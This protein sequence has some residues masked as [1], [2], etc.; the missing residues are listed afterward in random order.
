MSLSIPSYQGGRLPEA[1]ITNVAFLSPKSGEQTQQAVGIRAQMNT[2]KTKELEAT[3]ARL[4]HEGKYTP[5][6]SEHLQ[7]MESWPVPDRFEGKT[8]IENKGIGIIIESTLTADGWPK[9]TSDIANN[10]AKLGAPTHGFFYHDTNFLLSA[11]REYSNLEENEVFRHRNILDV[12]FVRDTLDFF[13]NGN[14]TSVDVALVQNQMEG[15]VHELAQKIKNGESLDLTKL[16]SK[17]TT[18]GADVTF[19]QVLAFQKVG[20]ALE[21]AFDAVTVGQLHTQEYAQMGIAKALGDYYGSDKGQIGEM[22]S[23]AINRSYDKGIVKMKQTYATSA[24]LFRP[25]NA[26]QKDAVDVGLEIANTF[27]KLDTSSEKNIKQDFAAK[28]SLIQQMVQNHCKQFNSAVSHV[29][30][31]GDMIGLTKYFNLWM[32]Q[33]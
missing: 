27:S 30:L 9:I 21:G 31:A 8:I 7:P 32:D 28:S 1:M 19:S 26:R 33:V 13:T 15:V 11:A 17:L 29:G 5:M 22:F 6:T 14:F 16:Q 12:N 2:T 20:K 3:A 24:Y 25:W 4:Y 18:G 10:S 23:N